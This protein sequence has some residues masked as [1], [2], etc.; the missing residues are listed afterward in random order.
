MALRGRPWIPLS[1]LRSERDRIVYFATNR[2]ERKPEPPEPKHA[3]PAAAGETEQEAAA[4][5]P[6]G[7]EPRGEA[8]SP[9]DASPRQVLADVQ[10]ILKYGSKPSERMPPLGSQSEVLG[11]CHWSF[12]P[13]EVGASV[14]TVDP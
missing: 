4:E 5:A 9:A 10:L 8:E 12:A 3:P 6:Q 14:A 11:H 1:A 7:A 2:A 13:A